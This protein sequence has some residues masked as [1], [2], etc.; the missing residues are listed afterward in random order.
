MLE[1]LTF[2]ELQFISKCRRLGGGGTREQLIEKLSN[3]LEVETR[4]EKEQN[5]RIDKLANQLEA[6]I[7]G[8]KI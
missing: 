1:K 6:L 7:Q 5:E 4:R 8:G 3:V 2:R